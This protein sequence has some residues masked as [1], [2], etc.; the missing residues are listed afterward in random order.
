VGRSFGQWVGRLVSV[1]SVDQWVDRMVTG[2]LG[3][4]GGRL[5]GQCEVG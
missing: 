1:M 5:D 2:S 4:S 3:R